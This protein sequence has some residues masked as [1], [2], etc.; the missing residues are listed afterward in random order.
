MLAIFSTYAFYEHAHSDSGNLAALIMS[1]LTGRE[2]NGIAAADSH[3][4]PSQQTAT[5]P[6][7]AA[8][9]TAQQQYAQYLAQINAQAARRG[10]ESSSEGEG[11][12]G[13]GRRLATTQPAPAPA[14]TQAA[15]PAQS[16]QTQPA[17]TSA[18]AQPQQPQGQYK[19]GTYTGPSVFVY[20]G[21]VQVQAIIQGGK[22]ADVKFLQYPSDRSTSQY[23]NSQAMPMLTQEA[24]AAQS[25]NVS[26]VSGASE[27]SSGFVQ[28]LGP[29][30]AQAH[31]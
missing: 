30:L 14:Q 16:A 20:Y 15:T 5:T 9:A 17:Q 31:A 21:N 13:E 2:Q 29:A 24:I 8:S 22:I 25:A 4:T 27:T 19:D 18:P 7:P 28:S 1:D 3:T 26:G 10:D 6:A 23:I 11:E 12:G